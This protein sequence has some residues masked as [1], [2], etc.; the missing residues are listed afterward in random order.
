MQR[1]QF[2]MQNQPNN[3]NK[4]YMNDFHDFVQNYQ[5]NP[6]KSVQQLLASGQM[7]QQTY[8]MLYQKF[9]EYQDVIQK[10]FQKF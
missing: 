2:P 8:N 1:P 6:E 5:G 4:N 3:N 10:L 7:S 9:F